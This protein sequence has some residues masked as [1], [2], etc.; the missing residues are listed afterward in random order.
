MI[1]TQNAIDQIDE[2]VAKWQA[3]SFTNTEELSDLLSE[4]T[5]AVEETSELDLVFI[6]ATPSTQSQPEE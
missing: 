2:F 4:I 1:L 3:K 5:S 6:P